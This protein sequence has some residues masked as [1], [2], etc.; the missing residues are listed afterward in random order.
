MRVKSRTVEELKHEFN[1]FNHLIVSKVEANDEDECDLDKPFACK[2]QFIQKYL[3]GIDYYN[4]C[5]QDNIKIVDTMEYDFVRRRFPETMDN[6]TQ[7]VKMVQNQF[8]STLK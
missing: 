1:P 4:G 7:R 3:N 5:K 2:D 6:V 8:L